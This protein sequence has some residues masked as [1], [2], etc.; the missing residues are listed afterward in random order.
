MSVSVIIPAYNASNVISR[1]VASALAQTKQPS[2][3]IVVDD[4]S[5]DGTADVVRQLSHG[6]PSVKLIK[7]DVN[8]G[9]SRARN[10]GI[11][12]ANSEWIAIL[13]ADDAW[14]S[15]RLERLL[16]IASQH[17]ADFVADNQILYDVG[18]QKETRVAFE[19][20]WQFKALNVEGLF[21]NEI[22]DQRTPAYPPLKP[23]IRRQ[24]LASSGIRY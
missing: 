16:A 3:V 11:A 15:N 1:S 7:I 2:E 12:A 4:A 18:A 17:A 19:G 9:P 13:D 21:L 8:S 14:K 10:I 20:D 5:I 6:S 23:I 22:L 24:F